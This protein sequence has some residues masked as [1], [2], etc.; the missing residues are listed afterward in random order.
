MGALPH[1]SALFSQHQPFIYLHLLLGGGG[2]GGGGEAE[3]ASNIGLLEGEGASPPWGEEASTPWGEGASTH[4]GVG[5][6]ETMS[7]H[8][9]DTEGYYTTFH[10]F[11][12]FQVRILG[13]PFNKWRWYKY[14]V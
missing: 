14:S 3:E 9:C 5:R 6:S 10:D 13:H 12:G 1:I 7:V 11:D 2:G 4:W 8:S